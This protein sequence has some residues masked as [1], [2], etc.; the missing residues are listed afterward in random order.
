[1]IAILGS[2][3]PVFAIILLGFVGRRRQFLPDLFWPH[4]ERLTFYVLFPSLLVANAAGADLAGLAVGPMLLAM[5]AAIAVVVALC[6]PLRPRLGLD[7]PAFTSLIQCSV[8]PNVYVAIGAA[9]ALFGAEGVTL[10][11]IVLAVNVPFVNLIAV[12]ALVRYGR[13]A[14]ARRWRDTVLPVLQNPLIIACLLGLALNVANVG[15]PPV[16]GPTLEILGRAAL[17][18][19]LLAVGAGLDLA[20]ARAAGP[21]VATAAGLKLIVLPLVTFGLCAALD[22]TGAARGTAILYAATPISATAYVMAR[23]M[24]GDTVIMAGA[25]A[26]STI[27]AA[28]TM[29]LLLALV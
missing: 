4:A 22:V 8:R 20:A 28:L 17:P 25:I 2:L 15:L 12:F 24:G 13:G 26:A 5:L 29:P 21:T 11:G 1:M 19:G 16:I 3:A 9:Y 14:G 6:W 18:I 23:Q 10:V 27:A 7:G